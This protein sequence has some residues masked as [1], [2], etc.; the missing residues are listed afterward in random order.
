MLK[1]ASEPSDE[2]L[3]IVGLYIRTCLIKLC[4]ASLKLCRFYIFVHLLHL[5]PAS[6]MDASQS[7]MLIQYFETI[8]GFIVLIPSAQLSV[9]RK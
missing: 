3:L 5:R 8:I 6:K 2:L 4:E 7:V 9:S 1:L